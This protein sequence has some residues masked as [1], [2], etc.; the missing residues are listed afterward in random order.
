MAVT[1]KN[2]AEKVGVSRQAVAAALSLSGSGRVSPELKKRILQVAHEMNYVP[3]QAARRLKGAPIRSI[4]LYGAPFASVLTQGYINMISEELNRHSY[5]MLTNYGFSEEGGEYAVRK[6]MAKGVDGIIVTT[7]ENPLAKIKDLA[8]PYVYC[9]YA[10]VE[11]FDLVV[12]HR[13]GMY[14]AGKVIIGKGRKHLCFLS[15][16]ESAGIHAQPSREKF[17]GIQ[18]A[19][20]ELGAEVSSL[21]VAACNGEAGK[22]IEEIRAKKIDAIFCCN[23]YF[24]GRMEQVLLSAGFRIPEDV[25]IIGYDGLSLCDLCPVPLTTIVQPIREFASRTVEILLKRI[26]QREQQR[27]PMEIKLQPYYYPSFSTGDENK[28]LEQLPM[29]NSFNTLEYTWE[30]GW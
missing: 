7:Q 10:I 15:T 23:D 8:V 25:M 18:Q 13:N 11:G 5:D 2:I 1:L 20:S 17:C 14:Q 21:Y 9:P 24:A 3:N 29:F 6:L 16:V 26:E 19:A 12:D 4:G 27:H 30:N 28:K 22:I